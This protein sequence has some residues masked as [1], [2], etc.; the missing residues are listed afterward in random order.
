MKASMNEENPWDGMVNVDVVEGIMEPFAMDEM[1]KALGIMKNGKASGP[2]WIDKEH[3]ASSGKQ[4]ILQIAN[5][6]LE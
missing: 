2:T 4:F 6:M 3:L 1:E 5:K